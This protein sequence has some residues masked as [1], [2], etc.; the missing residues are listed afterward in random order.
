MTEKLIQLMRNQEK[1][2]IQLLQLLKIQKDLI[3]KKDA[4]ALEGIV[5]KLTTCSKMIAQEEV[6]RRKL[7]N[8]G[9]IK[10]FVRNENNEELTNTYAK[11]TSIINEVI[12]QKDTNNLLIKQQISLNAKLLEI[13]NPNREIKT[14]NSYGRC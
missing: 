14:Y 6:E 7:L 4:F 5:D 2:L 3:I 11:I 10:E 1:Y 8:N 12:L 9:S 13:I